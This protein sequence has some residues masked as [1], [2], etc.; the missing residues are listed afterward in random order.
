MS[1]EDENRLGEMVH[2]HPD[3]LLLMDYASGALGE[4]ESLVI[5]THAA[6]CPLCRRKIAE[7]EA[8]GGAALGELDAAE[9]ADDA[10]AGVMARL[11]QSLEKPVEQAVAS[12]HAD[13]GDMTVPQPLRGY[14]NAALEDL[15]W[16]NVLRGLDEVTLQVG[17]NDMV[18]T[19]MMRIQPGAAMPQH[20]H[21]GAELTLVLKGAFADERGHFQRGDLAF[22]DS[23]VE[24]KPIA[25]DHEVCYCLA[26]TTAPLR[27]T[28][29]IGRLINPFIRY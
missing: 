21:E 14:L 4:A 29:P 22:T 26:V 11:D 16:T 19:K 24:H 12:A 6:L 3:D 17:S 1:A 25:D 20:T 9:M 2:H 10:L 28:G 15:P 13:G 18:R 23:D 27:L 8:V 5:A 7:Y